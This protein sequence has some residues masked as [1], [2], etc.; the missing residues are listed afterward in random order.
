[1]NGLEKLTKDDILKVMED[2][3]N[4]NIEHNIDERTIHYIK[5]NG[6][7]YPRKFLVKEA[8]KRLD[9]D[10]EKFTTQQAKNKLNQLFKDEKIEHIPKYKKG[11]VKMQNKTQPLNQIL[12]GPPGTGKTYN[13]INRAL[14]IILE[15]EPNE[16]ISELLEKNEREKLKLKF[17]EYKEKGQIE[18]VTFHQSYGYE[19]F[20]EG[21]KAESNKNGSLSYSIEDGIF[22]KICKKASVKEEENID[23]VIEELKNQL[24]ENYIEIDTE[25]T[26]FKVTYRGGETFRISP[27]NSKNP[28]KDYPVNIEDIKKLYRKEKTRNDIYNSTYSVGILNYL[29]KKGLKKYEEIENKNSKSYVLIIDEINRGNISKIFGELITLIEESKR[30][31]ADEEIKIKLP[32]SKKEAWIFV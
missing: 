29:Y 13:T 2:F 20:V 28:D 31:G 23:K 10:D 19:E 16:E 27:E 25:K 8:M 7:E 18:F 1:M 4:P 21:I 14:E 3:R 24:E 30:I 6:F 12:Y 32:Y 11:E 15:K 26:K 22:K 9:L 5:I 17:D